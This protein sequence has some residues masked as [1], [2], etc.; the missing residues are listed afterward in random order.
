[1]KIL[2]L[3]LKSK[4]YNMIESGIKTEEYREIKDF[5]IKRLE[6]KH[7]DIVQFSYGYTKKIMQFEILNI[8]KG[9]GN[10]DWGAPDFEVYK[11][12]LG[13]RII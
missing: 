9:I 7:Y 1:M 6:N 12:S 10:P 2:Y 8:E 5:W 4:W 13:N 11:I 3:P